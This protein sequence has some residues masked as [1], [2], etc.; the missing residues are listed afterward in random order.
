L[1]GSRPFT[2]THEDTEFEDRGEEEDD[3][4]FMT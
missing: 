3:S 2:V 1:I 4:S